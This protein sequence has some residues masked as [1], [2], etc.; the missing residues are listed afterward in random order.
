MKSNNPLSDISASAVVSG[1]VAVV[2][3]HPS[4]RGCLTGNF[5]IAYTNLVN[6]LHYQLLKALR[7]KDL[8]GAQQILQVHIKEAG[9]ILVA[10]LKGPTVERS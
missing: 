8:A 9:E 1:F 2:V 6:D 3:G 5:I 4:S 10:H 7:D